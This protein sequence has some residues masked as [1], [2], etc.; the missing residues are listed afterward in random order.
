LAAEASA[1][2]VG[3]A[4]AAAVAAATEA[5]EPG[6]TA[7]VETVF[8]GEADPDDPDALPSMSDVA[9]LRAVLSETLATVIE[10]SPTTELPAAVAART[11]TVVRRPTLGLVSYEDRFCRLE[12][13]AKSLE[14]GE[15]E[16][17]PMFNSTYS[18]A[19]HPVNTNFLINQ[20]SLNAEESVQ[21]VRTF[22]D[23]Y[24][25]DVGES[26]RTLSVQGV[27]IE[28]KNFPWL[29]E[30]RAN[31][32]QYLRARQ[33]ILR[34][35]MAYLTIDDTMYAGYIV[36]SSIS[37]NVTPAWEL[38]PFSFTMVLRSATDLRAE[39]LFGTSQASAGDRTQGLLA[40]NIG[41]PDASSLAQVAE[42]VSG[43]F[44]EGAQLLEPAP[45]EFSGSVDEA[46]TRVNLDHLVDVARRINASR[47]SDLIN[48][49]GLRNGYLS[50]RMAE[51]AAIGIS[52]PETLQKYGFPSRYEMSVSA[53][54]ARVQ[55]EYREAIEAGVEAAR[56]GIS[57]WKIRL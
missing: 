37:R 41:D 30:W 35:A 28:S 42:L 24:L 19:R 18:S 27:L 39:N 29:S 31:Y 6:T 33:C 44:D 56:E 45:L 13:F 34:K 57:N 20:V 53:R 8:E 32:D 50:Q 12:M 25:S 14:G 40:S 38:V 4:A 26:P 2:S 36:S 11:D 23:Y 3:A 15:G 43:Y 55:E 21:V 48:L 9:E 10:A 49:Q 1:D 16:Y 46:V 22:G 17:I 52:S 51:F 5:G 47:G 54:R 7:D